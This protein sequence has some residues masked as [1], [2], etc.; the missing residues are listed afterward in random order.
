MSSYLRN[1][2]IKSTTLSFIETPIQELSLYFLLKELSIKEDEALSYF[3]C[4][5][6]E[7]YSRVKHLH[8]SPLKFNY[9]KASNRVFLLIK[10]IQMALSASPER[11]V[12]GSELGF[13]NKII[14]AIFKTKRL[15]VLDDGLFSIFRTEKLHKEFLR[16]ANVIHKNKR[17]YYFS[18]FKKSYP[19]QE[20]WFERPLRK[21]SSTRQSH[22][23]EKCVFFISSGIT[24]DGLDA[25]IELRILKY[26][27]GLWPD[28]KFHLLPHRLDE[29]YQTFEL[30]EFVTK[31]RYF[32]DW[33]I[34]NEFDECIFVSFFSS[35]IACIDTTRHV[36]LYL[37]GY[38]ESFKWLKADKT[39][40]LRAQ[41]F[42]DKNNIASITIPNYVL[43]DN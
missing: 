36:V 24:I 3:I 37:T 35:S 34:H 27:K 31:T 42:F 21:I 6:K 2:S 20:G 39:N 22:K 30:K 15:V 17:I 12:I 13:I 4:R 1:K 23:Y 18:R 38:E 10:I 5:T 29:H 26:V 41:D 8:D 33:Y 7:E 40:V 28:Y 16:I 25:G 32:E 9:V 11:I 19:S 43:K 14:A